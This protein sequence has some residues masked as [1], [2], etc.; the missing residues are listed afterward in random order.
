MDFKLNEGYLGTAPPARIPSTIDQGM[1]GQE[2]TFPLHP[3]SNSVRSSCKK[4]VG[5]TR[6]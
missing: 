2:D 6:I 4:I 1:S 5:V 3:L